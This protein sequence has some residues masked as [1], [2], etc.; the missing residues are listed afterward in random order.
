MRVA[1]AYQGLRVGAPVFNVI[2]TCAACISAHLHVSQGRQQ[3]GMQ[4]YAANVHLYHRAAA[5]DVH[6]ATCT[7][8]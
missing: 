5:Q 2:P 4:L 1:L 3:L 8:A 6:A 7:L